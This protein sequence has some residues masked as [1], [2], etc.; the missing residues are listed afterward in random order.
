MRPSISSADL[1]VLLHEADR[2]ARRFAWRLSLPA[3][4]L[5]DV[6]QEFLVDL[7]ARFSAY[8][9]ARGSLGGFANIVL[10]NRAAELATKVKRERILYGTVPISLDAPILCNPGVNR[11]DMIAEDRG[12]AAL[13]GQSADSFILAEQRIDVARSLGALEAGDQT[14]CAALAQSNIRNLAASGRGSRSSLYRQL[15]ELRFALMA[16]GLQA[17]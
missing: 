6:R 7:I 13:Y 17:A 3:S 16:L 12:L 4:E 5:D 2:A 15:K 11:G 14:I 8:E 9:P 1:H 10:A